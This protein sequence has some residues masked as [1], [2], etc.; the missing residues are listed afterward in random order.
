MRAAFPYSLTTTDTDNII[1]LG[2]TVVTTLGQ[3]LP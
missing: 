3:Y 2:L 1:M